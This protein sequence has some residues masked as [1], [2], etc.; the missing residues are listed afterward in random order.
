MSER[1]ITDVLQGDLSDNDNIRWLYD[2]LI[3]EVEASVEKHLP[4]ELNSRVTARAMA[5]TSLRRAIER[6]KRDQAYIQSSDVFRAL[7]F[8]I[9]QRVRCNAIRY[10]KAKQRDARRDVGGSDAV[11]HVT[12]DVIAPDEK[13]AMREVVRATISELLNEDEI[14]RML[15]NLLGLVVGMNAAE[16]EDVLSRHP[17]RFKGYRQPTIRSQIK[18]ARD[19][20]REAVNPE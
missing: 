20:V 9:A 19:R 15:H 13:A 12:R 3:A 8:R 7:L 5:E 2:Q 1:T 11:V 18:R 14:E 10:E 16:I 6:A 17:E 4:E